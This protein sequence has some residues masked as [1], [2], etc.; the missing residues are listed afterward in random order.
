MHQYGA[1]VCRS[2]INA[3]Y[4]VRKGIWHK[5]KAKIIMQTL[6]QY[7]PKAENGNLVACEF[8]NR[9]YNFR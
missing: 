8:I 3:E 7:D 9:I 5:T 4:C 6:I 1:F 2:H